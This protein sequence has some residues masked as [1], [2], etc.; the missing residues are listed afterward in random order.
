[1][2]PTDRR[3]PRRRRSG[4]AHDERHAQEVVVMQRSLEDHLV[5]TEELAVVRGRDHER[6]VGDPRSSSTARMRPI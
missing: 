6:V 1:M 4:T 3:A 2:L 5:M